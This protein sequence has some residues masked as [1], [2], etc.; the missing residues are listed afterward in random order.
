M[1]KMKSV[2]YLAVRNNAI[3]I[4][5]NEEVRN[6]N[7]LS[8]LEQR[9]MNLPE[10]QAGIGLIQNEYHAFDVFDHTMEVVRYVKERSSD[11]DLIAAAYLH[12]IGKP[13]T[14]KPRVYDGVLQKDEEGRQR[15]TFPNHEY[16]GEE[17]V[18]EMSNKFFEENNLNQ[19]KIGKLVGA[20]YLPMIGIAKTR[21]TR[22]YQ[23]FVS[24]FN[25]LAQEIDK[26]GLDREE[27]MNL[28]HADTL[29]KGNTFGDGEELLKIKE[30]L[31]NKSNPEEMIREVYEMQLREAEN[32]KYGYVI[33]EK[34]GA[35][36]LVK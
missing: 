4:K 34:N 24:A 33:K 23:E 12:D 2:N 25:S 6:E 20:H 32:G 11:K 1:I 21:K 5:E 3:K 17:M 7:T 8:D 16:V 26:T 27:L 18:R 35:E 29:G 15:H 10:I 9:L 31:V 28:F 19:E 22:N 30:I 14:A 13:V 36:E